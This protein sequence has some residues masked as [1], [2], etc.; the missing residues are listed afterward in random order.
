MRFAVL[1][2]CALVF[3]MS[4]V[5][6][7]YIAMKLNA[8]HKSVCEE[9]KRTVI[10]LGNP[11]ADFKIDTKEDVVISSVNN[12]CE[13]YGAHAGSNED[14]FKSGINDADKSTGGS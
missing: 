5:V 14:L 9:A 3:S 13:K 11:G 7:I 2:F 12:E 10:V 1:I 4:A 8:I 6:L